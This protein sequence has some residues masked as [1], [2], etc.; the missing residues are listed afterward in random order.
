MQFDVCYVP[1]PESDRE[2]GS[3][4]WKLENIGWIRQFP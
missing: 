2:S 3:L 4:P 1:P